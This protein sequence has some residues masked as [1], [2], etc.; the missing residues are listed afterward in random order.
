MYI[1]KLLCW[2]GVHWSIYKSSY[3]LSNI[4]CLNS[5]VCCSLSS[6]MPQ[7]LG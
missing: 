6:T 3:K 4:P 5:P 7:F 1:F 2:V